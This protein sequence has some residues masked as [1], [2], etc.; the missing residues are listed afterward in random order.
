MGDDDR[1]E[2]N[3]FEIYEDDEY[4]DTCDSCGS[5]AARKHETFP[6]YCLRTGGE[7]VEVGESGLF[8]PIDLIE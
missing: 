8:H 2:H 6:F 1:A 7:L 4:V 5:L 3:M